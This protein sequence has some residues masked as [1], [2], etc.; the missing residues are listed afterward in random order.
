MTRNV[1]R[2]IISHIAV[3]LCALAVIV[4][5]VPLGAGMIGA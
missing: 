5:L 4:A 1:R 3:T 2:R